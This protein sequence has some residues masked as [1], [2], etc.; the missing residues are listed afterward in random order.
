MLNLKEL[1]HHLR[2]GQKDLAE[3]LGVKQSQVSMMMN[4]RRDIRETHVAKL[5]AAFGDKI[6]P[7][8][9]D[10]E[11]PLCP[12]C[13]DR[14]DEA[15]IVEEKPY[16]NKEA[17]ESRELD[18]REAVESGS[19]ALDRKSLADFV[20]PFDYVQPVI[21]A[22]MAPFFK[23]GDLLLLRFLPNG[24]ELIDG[25][26]YSIDTTAYGCLLR[27]VK[28]EPD[29]NYRLCATNNKGFDDITLSP[30][31]IRSVALIVHLLRTGFSPSYDFSETFTAGAR[32]MQQVLDAQDQL[33]AEIREQNAEVREQNRRNHELVTH[34][35]NQK[36]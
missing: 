21:S 13:A 22:A 30:A 27:R 31:E 16:A 11:T 2:L 10:S 20:Q 15:V 19:S 7:F 17:V 26:V 6:L 1:A 18:L 24:A 23:V 5:M 28:K 34:I 4:G 3:V 8:L 25:E 9:D 33:I 35:I 29:G 32:N 36:N 12:S 14:I